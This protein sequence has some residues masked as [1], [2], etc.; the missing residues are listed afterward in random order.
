M[1]GDIYMTDLVP[2]GLRGLDLK[3]TI[4]LVPSDK[5][6]IMKNVDRI[7]EGRLKIRK[8]QQWWGYTTET[9]PPAKTSPVVVLAEPDPGENLRFPWILR[10]WAIDLLAPVE[11]G[12]GVSRVHVWVGREGSDPDTPVTWT[13]FLGQVDVDQ[14]RPDVAKVYGTQF[15]RCGFYKQIPGWK[16]GDPI[17][18]GVPYKLLVAA[19]SLVAQAWVSHL[20]ISSIVFLE[21]QITA[22]PG[23]HPY[24]VPPVLGVFDGE[25]GLTDE[26]VS[27]ESQVRSELKCLHV[28]VA[29]ILGTQDRTEVRA[30]VG[31]A[32]EFFDDLQALSPSMVRIPVDFRDQ[33]GSSGDYTQDRSYWEVVLPEITDRGISVCLVISPGII[34]DYGSSQWTESRVR[35]IFALRVR[36]LVSYVRDHITAVEIWPDPDQVGSLMSTSD[37]ADLWTRVRADLAVVDDIDTLTLVL[38]TVTMNV[39][40]SFLSDLYAESDI[41]DYKATNG[42]FPWDVVGLAVVDAPLNDPAADHISAVRSWGIDAA[43]TVL[44]EAKDTTRPI[45]ITRFGWSDSLVGEEGQSDR[46]YEG[47]VYLDDLEDAPD[48]G[49][50]VQR[51][52]W[53]HYQS[54]TNTTYGLL[55]DDGRHKRAYTFFRLLGV[56]SVTPIHPPGQ[57][58]DQ[59]ATVLVGP[60]VL[61]ATGPHVHT[62]HRLNDPRTGNFTRLV[63]VGGNLYTGKRG[64]LARI[65]SGYHT[66]PIQMAEAR[67]ALSGQPWAFLA[68]YNRMR[69]VRIDG[70]NLALGLPA[71]TRA[72]AAGMRA[73]QRTTIDTFDS[74]NGWIDPKNIGPFSLDTSH[75]LEDG[76]VGRAVRFQMYAP[77]ITDDEWEEGNVNSTNWAFWTKEVH[78]DLSRVGSRDASDDDLIHVRIRPELADRIVDIKL[79]FVVNTPFING[80]FGLPGTSAAPHAANTDAYMK[81]FR[82]HDFQGVIAMEQ[83]PKDASADTAASEQIRDQLDRVDERK[84]RRKTDPG[85]EVRQ[86]SRQKSRG[87]AEELAPGRVTWSEFGVIDITLRRGDFLRIGQ[88]DTR[89]WRHVTGLAIA[90]SIDMRRGE[91]NSTWVDFDDLYLTG[92][93]NIDNAEFGAD[94]YDWRYVNYDPR[95]GDKSNP[96][97][98]MPEAARIDTPRRAV[99]VTPRPYGNAA[100]RQRIYRRGGSLINDW[101]YCGQTMDNHFLRS[102]V[103]SKDCCSRVE[104]RIVLDICTTP[105]EVSM[106]R[107]RLRT[108]SR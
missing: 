75:T 58:I 46:L 97:P 19:W 64:Q 99:T 16:F 98:I 87:V 21:S 84:S 40:T 77:T 81:V 11:D 108:R 90:V 88:D 102:G 42:V 86:S 9:P 30:A 57:V 41:V 95:T 13:T 89:D 106:T 12:A 49:E 23:T 50:I 47:Y 96:S 38:G 76:V 3:R 94:H 62:L 104:I 48:A 37:Y 39:S 79:Y 45:W 65:D 4:D 36:E 53:W 67:P 43:R 63:G 78:L 27:T 82:Q 105:N 100:I 10:G 17:Q 29:E 74:G 7:E 59:N 107:G 52:F 71:P 20:T 68:N 69:K 66:S 25:Q 44:T 91:Q 31:R 93:Y 24:Q 92:G 5:L 14:A 15:L 51:A 70:L 32:T 83:T 54:G 85:A 8:G 61:S 72:A 26:N 22:V 73:E 56:G 55:D 18:A 60:S 6:T 1:A 2:L 33:R 28:D 80:R 103:R 101:Y 35:E 34:S